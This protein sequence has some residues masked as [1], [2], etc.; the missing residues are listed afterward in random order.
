[1]SG[2]SIRSTRFGSLNVADE[3]I[4]EFP[5]GL[6]GLPH[7]RRF[8]LFEP[9]IP[10]SPFRGMVSLDDP[11]IGLAIADPHML[12]ADYEAD[13][14]AEYPVLGIETPEE[15]ALYVILTVP[16]DNPVR[17]T[18]NLLA[19]LLVNKRLRI[20]RQVVLSESRYWTR[21]P[22]IAPRQQS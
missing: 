4:W 12:F 11:E 5:E 13:V 9:S 8:A 19:P 21:H 7:L 15:A 2:L 10:D 22:I 17:T 3:G 20:G 16:P 18:A 6:I 1:M 14:S